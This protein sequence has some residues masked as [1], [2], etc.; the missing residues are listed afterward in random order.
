MIQ[1]PVSSRDIDIL[2]SLL[3]LGGVTHPDLSMWPVFR[4]LNARLEN[5]AVESV[6]PSGILRCSISC[7]VVTSKYTEQTVPYALEWLAWYFRIGLLVNQVF[8]C[9]PLK[10]QFSPK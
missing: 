4:V 10:G 3:Y 1:Q 5:V 9:F 6:L 8:S 2:I 7:C